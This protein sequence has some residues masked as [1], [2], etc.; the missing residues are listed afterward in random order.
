MTMR[1]R[2]RLWRKEKI[3]NSWIDCHHHHQLLF[4]LHS[5]SLFFHSLLLL[6]QG[7]FHSRTRRVV[8]V[9]VFDQLAWTQRV[10]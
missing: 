6:C 2:G 10:E 4:H 8:S 9:L 7:R 3:Q 5:M 1:G